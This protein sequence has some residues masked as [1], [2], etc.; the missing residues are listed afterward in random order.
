[1]IRINIFYTAYHMVTQ[2]VA[3]T[4][5]GFQGIKRCIKY[6][7]IDPHKTIFYIYNSYSGSNAIRLI[8]S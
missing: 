5:P 4:I 7:Y 2:T 6:L 1:M 3:P 8:W